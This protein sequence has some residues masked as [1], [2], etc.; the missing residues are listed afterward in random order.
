MT[1]DDLD[2]HDPDP[3][4]LR[5]CEYWRCGELF[6]ARSVQ[7]RFCRKACRSRQHKWQ[8]AQDRRQ[9]RSERRGRPPVA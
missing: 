9:R 6:E 3:E 1:P 5:E 2:L 7:H 4:R 8:R